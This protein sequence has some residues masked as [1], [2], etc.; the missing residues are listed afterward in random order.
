MNLYQEYR[1]VKW[2]QV[3][4]HDKIVKELQNRSKAGT[5][6]Q[7][8]YFHG[9][10]GTGKTTLARLVAMSIKCTAIDKE[11]GNPCGQCKECRDIIDE[12]YRMDSHHWNGADFNKDDVGRVKEIVATKS[13]VS[14][15]KIV[16]IDEFQ[17]VLPTS[18]AHDDFLTILENKK[19]NVHFLLTSMDDSKTSKALKN[20]TEVFKLN[21]I[22]VEKIAIYLA[23]ICKAKGIKLD[24]AKGNTLVTIAEHSNGSMRSACAIL[25]RCIFGE[26]WD[27]DELLHELDIA[28][29]DKIIDIAGKLLTKD[30]SVL[31]YPLSEETIGMVRKTLLLV[32]K[33][34]LGIDIGFRQ[35]EIGGLYNQSADNVKKALE[36]LH[37]LEAMPFYTQEIVDYT[38]LKLIDSMTA[39]GKMLLQEATPR[40]RASA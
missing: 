35:K 6:P 8:M 1:P 34:Q 21:P 29:A 16:F 9:G 32:Y 7:A 40:R 18:K 28:S 33:K 12:T 30:T 14:K 23:S 26:I 20:R 31:Q 27:E 39:P 10:S 4:G 15:K 17:K 2:E 38:L 13:I 37:G 5:W 36:I 11:T 3:L 19:P 25:E 22:S 24:E